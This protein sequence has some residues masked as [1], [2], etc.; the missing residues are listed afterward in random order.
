MYDHWPN[1]EFKYAIIH[2]TYY[3]V[4]EHYWTRVY[5]SITQNSETNPIELIKNKINLTI[6]V[7]YVKRILLVGSI[8]YNYYQ[9]MVILDSR[10]IRSRQEIIKYCWT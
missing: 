2:M 8:L 4:N 5:S 6:F 1:K 10:F 3:S 9:S 7:L